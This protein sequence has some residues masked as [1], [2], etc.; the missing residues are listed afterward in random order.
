MM[1]VK[2]SFTAVAAL[3][4]AFATSAAI[5]A[6]A[7]ETPVRGGVLSFVVGSKI[8]SYDGHRETT[9]GMIHPIRPFYSTLLRV[10]PDNPQSP[11]DIICD[12]CEGKPQTTNG[13]KTITFKIKSNVVFHDGT[14]LT[15]ADVKA[16]LDKIMFPPKGI[17]SSRKAWYSQVSSVDAPNPTTLHVQLKRP[18]AAMIPALASPFNFT[19]SKKDLDEHGYSWHQK[20][21]N[22]TGAF[23]FVE[24]QP[25]AFVEGARFDKFHVNGLPYL[26]GYRAISAPKMS[27]RLQAIRGNR[28]A[29]EFRGFPP[30]ARDDL[31]RA[32][33]KKIKVQESNWNCLMGA[34]PNQK[35]KRFQDKRVRQALTLAFD[36]WGGSRYLSKIALVKTVGGVTF[37]GH[38]LEG[39]K[40][41]LQTLNGYA[42]DVRASRARAKKL[43]QDAGHPNLKVTLWNRAVDQPYKVVGTWYIDQWRKIGAKADQKVLPSGPWYAGLRK[44]RDFDVAVD[45]NCQTVINPTID[46]SKWIKGA[47][48][49]YSNHTDQKVTDMYLDM[50]NEADSKKQYQ[51]MRTYEKYILSDQVHYMTSFWWYKINPHRSYVKGW[52]IAPSHYLNQSLD[53]VWL[54]PKLQ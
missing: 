45:F 25:G 3:G 48:N 14:P 37:P 29:I 42:K 1:K 23:K 32:L 44:T 2:A 21:I 38:P 5:T 16:T 18:L 52:K 7:Q 20:N 35:L 46:V 9:F 49:N 43:L 19:Y 54:D 8:P 15:S 36:R 41:W 33:G 30:K 39:S 27:V 12:L 13:G 11:T 31:V 51:K 53:Q 40:R 50:L 34:S 26:D 47:G 28:A 17:P 24:H 6:S 4:A 22:G 10:N